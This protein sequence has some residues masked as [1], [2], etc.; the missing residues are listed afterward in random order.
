MRI[1]TSNMALPHDRANV[2]ANKCTNVKKSAERMKKAT[3]QPFR[4]AHIH[5]GERQ[6]PLRQARQGK[7]TEDCAEKPARKRVARSRKRIDDSLLP[8]VNALHP[9]YDVMQNVY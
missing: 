8:I 9:V 4:P 3:R 6:V 1:G 5:A 7:H 2:M